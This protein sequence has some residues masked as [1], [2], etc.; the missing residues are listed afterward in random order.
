MTRGL[1]ADS[2]N[3][4]LG[5]AKRI[6]TV[7]IFSVIGITQLFDIAGLRINTSPSLPVGIYITTSDP[8]AALVEFCPANPYAQLAIVRGYRSAGNCRDGAA[9]L[10]KPVIARSGDIID[11]SQSGITVNGTPIPNTAPIKADT[12]G[13]QLVPWRAGRYLAQA[14]DVWVASSFNRRSFD[15]RYFGPIPT[16]AIRN[17]LL[18]LITVGK[19]SE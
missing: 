2:S 17:R 3:R 14:G 11:V 8:N 19:R 1:F 12:S 9:P 18:P 5:D 4:R 15:S 7:S 10:L 13:R 16:S 6:A